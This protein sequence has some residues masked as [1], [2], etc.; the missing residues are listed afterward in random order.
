MEELFEMAQI[1][2]RIIASLRETEDEETREN[3][4]FVLTRLN[5]SI[6]GFT[7]KKDPSG[8][9]VPKQVAGEYLIKTWR[10]ARE[11]DILALMKKHLPS[12]YSHYTKMCSD[13]FVVARYLI[14]NKYDDLFKLEQTETR[15]NIFLLE[16]KDAFMWIAEQEENPEIKEKLKLT[17]KKI[18]DLAYILYNGST[19]DGRFV[20]FRKVASYV[21]EVWSLV[22]SNDWEETLS[23]HLVKE[24]A[25]LNDVSEAFG[26][27]LSPYIKWTQ[28]TG[29][30]GDIVL[31]FDMT[32]TDVLRELR[33]PVQEFGK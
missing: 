2:K 22:K 18:F 5:N 30:A 15:L 14:G 33:W 11:M 9:D 3:V 7:T 17:S 4:G 27:F 21:E 28:K 24:G 20:P 31:K 26:E 10:I 8:G 32:D 23:G 12:D 29:D 25:K 1:A 16:A 13:M 19:P 6:K